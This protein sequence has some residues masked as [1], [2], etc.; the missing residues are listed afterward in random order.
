MMTE[1]QKH[2]ERLVAEAADPEIGRS[3]ICHDLNKFC[4]ALSSDDR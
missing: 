3:K 2:A 1:A 4:E